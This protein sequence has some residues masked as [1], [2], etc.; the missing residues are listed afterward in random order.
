[1]SYINSVSIARLIPKVEAFVEDYM[2]TFDASHDFGHIQRVVRLA[3]HIAFVET[4][5]NPSLKLDFN[6]IHLAALL[7][8]INDRK[9]QTEFSEPLSTHLARL[10]WRDPALGE[11][12][13][14]I[15][16]HV[17][18]HKERQNPLAVTTALLRHPELAVVQDADRIDA[19]GAVG[20]GRLF[21]YGSRQ[22]ES[23]D[24]SISHLDQRLEITGSRMKTE[25]GKAIIAERIQRVKTFRDWWSEETGQTANLYME[26]ANT[27]LENSQA[28]DVYVR[29]R[30]NS[31]VSVA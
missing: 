29:E 2:S 17:S 20:I 1:M 3:Q 30:M 27:F 8:D 12:L 6:L 25:T 31:L 26:L 11:A 24:M 7:H 13:E 14:D 28:P 23:L 10:G 4:K 9:Y 18:F 19:I 22:E 5:K 16:S 15:I 21:V